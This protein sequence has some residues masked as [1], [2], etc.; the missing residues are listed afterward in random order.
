LTLET[1]SLEMH[2]DKTFVGEIKRGF[3]LL[4]YYF[5]PTGLRPSSRLPTLRTK[6]PGLMANNQT[7]GLLR[8][9]EEC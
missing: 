8:S 6:Q 3:D 2:S 4:R 1:L 5:S 7:Q 9:M